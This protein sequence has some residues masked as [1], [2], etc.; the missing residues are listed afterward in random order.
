[1]NYSP[2]DHGIETSHAITLMIPSFK[3]VNYQGNYKAYN[4]FTEEEQKSILRD[5][6]DESI[7]QYDI[8]HYSHGLLYFETHKDG[9][10][11][12]HTY[13]LNQTQDTIL[14]IQSYFCGKMNMRPN[15][16]QQV[17]NVFKP[18]NFAAWLTYCR[19]AETLEYDLAQLEKNI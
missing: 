7:K 5:F 13:I 2:F 14:K 17:F 9:R 19:K 4:L 6:F 12:A 8:S 18:D 15:Q 10:V 16:F 3:K 11:H 1:M